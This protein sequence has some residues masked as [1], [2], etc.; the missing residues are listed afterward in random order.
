MDTSVL[1]AD[2]RA[3]VSLARA[4]ALQMAG[5]SEQLWEE[6][7]ALGA[8]GHSDPVVDRLAHTWAL[9]REACQGGSISDARR[10]LDLLGTE[11]S[12]ASLGHFAAIAFHNAATAALAQGD[13][14]DAARLA[15]QT[16]RA[17]VGSPVDASIGPSSL[18][19][20]ALAL[21]ELGK[22]NEGMALAAE[23]VSAPDAHP[24]VLAD[25]AYLATVTGDCQRAETLE[26]RLRRLIA[27]GPAQ[28]GARHQAV[29]ARVTR[30]VASG[31]FEE[32]VLGAG[33]LDD[34]RLDELD[35]VTRSAY[36]VAL[37]SALLAMPTA[38]E[39]ITHALSAADSQKAWRWE[40]RLR[41]LE[42]A[43]RRDGENLARWVSDCAD[44][45]CLAILEMADAIG[46]SLH[47]IDPIP[48]GLTYSIARHPMRWRPVLVRQL[49]NP[50][51]PSASVAARLLTEFGTREDASS[52]AAYERKTTSS[53]RRVRLSRALVRRVSPT[54]RIHD[55]G[56][57]TYEVSGV[58]VRSSAARRKALALILF[59]V[60]RPRQT[61]TR[62][63]VMEELWP[64]Q[65]PASATNSLHQTL[66]F[67]R[68]D[69][70]PWQGGGATADY[71]PLDAELIYLDPELVQVDSVAFMR[72][73][74]EAL[75]SPDLAR[76]GP[77]IARLYGGHFAP[78]F[79][80]EDW[81]ADWRTLVHGQFLHL[82]QATAA[83][84][85]AAG[86]TQHAIDV[87]SRAVEID[88]LAFDL[89]ASLIRTLAR[90]GAAD[91]AADHYRHY[92]NLMKRE[93]GVRAPPYEELLK[94]TT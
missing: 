42:A 43:V 37:A 4:S 64:S 48:T 84:L 40:F 50:S 65:P 80:Y 81:A 1:D 25:A 22:V 24:D 27:S 61:A 93:L 9:M 21:A 78:E 90:A 18:V 83:A 51:N 91:A 14:E 5:Q 86:R 7:R 33:L 82:S 79:E 68:R 52:L 58:E 45:S 10:S 31:R 85:L 15:G 16:R 62:E 89:R 41:I 77:G 34:G 88:S 2:E 38:P 55:L 57:T 44:L 75:N 30:L 26:H 32:A 53:G 54:L 87:L 47:L 46:A 12:R 66:H 20:Q 39:D 60:T 29:V 94:E 67:V 49:G 63:Q 73:A 76:V 19:T 56:R 70:A 23:A 8:L 92:S 6:V 59:L 74:T 69:I 36:L 11:A 35:G 71:V 17:L 3:L 72:Q 28:V 13:F